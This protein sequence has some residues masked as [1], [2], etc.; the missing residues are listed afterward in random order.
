M[1]MEISWNSVEEIQKKKQSGV[2]QWHWP[3]IMLFSRTFLFFAFGFIILLILE[4][5]KID[6]PN[7]EVTRWWT[8]QVIGTNILC[9]FLLR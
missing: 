1:L 7:L 6:Q 9:F 5:F 8:Y 3:I 4:L 2:I